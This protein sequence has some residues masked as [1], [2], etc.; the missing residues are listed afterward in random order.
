MSHLM[1]LL[2]A[3][4]ALCQATADAQSPVGAL[5][6][7][8]RPV[9]TSPVDLLRRLLATNAAGRDVWLAGKPAAT[10]QY[11]EG[12]LREY[13]SMPAAELEARLQALQWRC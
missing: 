13:G 9:P 3:V 7:P 6:A 8:V 5:N 11:V 10:R 2:L 4:F 1:P 12:K